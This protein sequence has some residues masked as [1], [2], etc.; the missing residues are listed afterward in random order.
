MRNFSYK[1]LVTL[2][3][4]TS[5]APAPAVAADGNSIMVNGGSNPAAMACVSCHGSDGKGMPESGFPRLSGLPAGY[6]AKQLRDF[7]AGTREHALMQPVASALSDEEILNVANA[8]AA[9]AMVNVASASPDRPVQGTGAWIAQRG[10]WDRGIPECSSCHG[11]AGLGVGNSFPPLA[12]QSAIYLA[13]QLQAWKVKPAVA[14]KKHHAKKQELAAR[15]N[16]PNGLMQHIAADLTDAEI[17]A[18]AEYYAGIEVSDEPVDA[19]K[20]R[21]R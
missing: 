19:S 1:Y 10:A 4:L 2:L 20:L 21:L 11:P 3:C 17:K 16:D 8:Y 6:I 7:K 15:R 9:Q 13:A 5:I 12:G 18:V 14:D